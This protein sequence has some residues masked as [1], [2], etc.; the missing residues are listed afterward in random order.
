M[1]FTP[2]GLSRKITD[3]KPFTAGTDKM[4]KEDF[5]TALTMVYKEFGWDEKT[6]APTADSLDNYNLTDVKEDLQSRVCSRHNPAG[7]P[8][9]TARSFFWKPA[10]V[11][12]SFLQTTI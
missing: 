3:I 5:Q 6:G 1:M 11:R 10:I 12:A 7:G 2:S 8:P 4:E 9:L